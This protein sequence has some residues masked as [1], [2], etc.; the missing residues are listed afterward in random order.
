MSV[1]EGVEAIEGGVYIGQSLIEGG[2]NRRWRS[3]RLV[4]N[5][6]RVLI[7]GGMYV[8]S[9]SIEKKC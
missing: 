4:F 8:S 2:A 6:K 7:E 5:E 9:F 3:C 1:I